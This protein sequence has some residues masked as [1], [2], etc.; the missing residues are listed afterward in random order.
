MH[1][2][3]TYVQLLGRKRNF[4]NKQNHNANKTKHKI[5]PDRVNEKVTR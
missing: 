1:F 4:F 3:K 5:T 2:L